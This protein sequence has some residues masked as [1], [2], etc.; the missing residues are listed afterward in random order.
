MTD[1]VAADGSNDIAVTMD[2]ADMAALTSMLESP[3]PVSS[4]WC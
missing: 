4:P 1:F 3:S 2:V